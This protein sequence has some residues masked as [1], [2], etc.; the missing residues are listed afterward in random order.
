MAFAFKDIGKGYKSISTFALSINMP[1]PMKKKNHGKLS[2]VICEAYL[3]VAEA[4]IGRAG[5][6]V[7]N[8]MIQTL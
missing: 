8:I 2:D 4:S 7:Q 6:E 3:A 1:P 5:V